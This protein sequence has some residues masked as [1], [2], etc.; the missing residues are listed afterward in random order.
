M[1]VQV[2]YSQSTGHVAEGDPAKQGEVSRY[3]AKR[4]TD[5]RAHTHN[6][7]AIA[8]TRAAADACYVASLRILVCASDGW[9]LPP[10]LLLCVLL[11]CCVV[12]SG[13][14]TSAAT[15][16]P[17]PSPPA[18][19]RRARAASAR[20]RRWRWVVVGAQR[21]EGT[22]RDLYALVCAV[23]HTTHKAGR[24]MYTSHMPSR[25]LTNT[26]SCTHRDRLYKHIHAIVRHAHAT[27]SVLA[28]SH[29]LYT[30]MRIFVLHTAASGVQKLAAS[31]Q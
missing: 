27:Q 22:D 7:H 20:L 30:C 19:R 14:P 12:V 4:V 24:Q 25:T 6:A 28:L 3:I 17:A 21:R 5:T 10:L 13:S 16:P 29:V 2:L 23:T 18:A 26:Q 11:F 15:P 31:V 9:M 1:E 8:N